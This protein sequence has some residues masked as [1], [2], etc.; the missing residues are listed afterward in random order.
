MSESDIEDARPMQ[1]VAD[2]EEEMTAPDDIQLLWK[3]VM[4]SENLSKEY[5]A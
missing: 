4:L 5:L 3:N 1:P 2:S